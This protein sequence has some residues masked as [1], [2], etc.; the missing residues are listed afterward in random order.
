LADFISNPRAANMKFPSQAAILVASI[1]LAIRETI[2]HIQVDPPVQG[3]EDT[4]HSVDR[5]DTPAEGIDT[6]YN[7]VVD[8][9][10][11]AADGKAF[12]YIAATDGTCKNLRSYFRVSTDYRIT[13][14]KIAENPVF[15]GH[16]QAAHDAGFIRG[17]YHIA[18]PVPGHSGATEA[19]YFLDHGGRWN[20]DGTTLPG[21]LWLQ[22]M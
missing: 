8:W 9:T 10:G 7:P 14:I 1:A 15:A 21:A 2:A 3:E 17:A 12:V 16:Y 22:C 4:N 6:G 11:Y 13:R 5:R 20:A 18:H 19:D